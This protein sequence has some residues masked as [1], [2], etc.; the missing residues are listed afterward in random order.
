MS[1]FVTSG[2][3][4]GPCH[5]LKY[6]S[7]ARHSYFLRCHPSLSC[8]SGATSVMPLA[9]HQAGRSRRI[10]VDAHAEK[11]TTPASMTETPTYPLDVAEQRNA[12]D[13]PS[14]IARQSS[15]GLTG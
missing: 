12:E 13:S 5:R 3:H 4:S 14:G 2:A 6:R 11:F 7:Q 9:G 10:P 15:L 8:R 1:S